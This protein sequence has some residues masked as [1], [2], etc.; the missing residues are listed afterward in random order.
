MSALDDYKA[1]LK[2]GQKEARAEAG[3]GL[4]EITEPDH[5]ISE[6]LPSAEDCHDLVCPDADS[7]FAPPDC[8]FPQCH[9]GMSLAGVTYLERVK[10]PDVFEDRL[11]TD[12]LAEIKGDKYKDRVSRLRGMDKAAYKEKKKSLPVFAF[13]GRFIGNVENDRF[14]QSS[15]LFHYDIDKLSP[16]ELDRIK[17]QL[18][19]LPSC[20]FVFTSPSGKGLKGALRIDPETVKN[21]ADFKALF[22]VGEAY[23]KELDIVIDSSC[24]NVS[25]LCFVSH[26]PDLYIN[27]HADLFDWR[28]MVPAKTTATSP[29]EVLSLEGYAAVSQDIQ[30]ECLRRITNLLE[31]APE[32]DRHNARLKAGRLAGG[33]IAGGLIDEAFILSHLIKLSD[34]ISESGTTSKSERTTLKEAIEH[35]K[36]APIPEYCLTEPAELVGL[37]GSL[38]MVK[39]GGKSAVLMLDGADTID[40]MTVSGAR[41]Y[42]A[43][44]KIKTR[45]KKG[46]EKTIQAFEEWRTH[47]SRA[48]FKGIEFAP[49]KKGREGY[50]NMWRGFRVEPR[51]GD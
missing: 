39:L 2:A 7:A 24:K 12:A 22:A 26:D 16:E 37:L 15:G 5:I 20:V 47:G 46:N 23:F 4:Q 48:T 13:N 9:P 41:D 49:G 14:S 1:K 51:E 25:R 33:Y 31:G 29:V 40:T 6:V 21:D 32:G 30:D 35:G 36:A 28:S 45:D 17:S 27:W 3:Q 10:S 11:L 18:R 43:N 19:A 38:A 50:C 34:E 8:G 44:I 42:F